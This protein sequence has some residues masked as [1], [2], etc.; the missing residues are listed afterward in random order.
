MRFGFTPST[1]VMW[2]GSERIQLE[3]GPRAIV[4]DDM[5][6]ATV[7]ELV[8]GRYEAPVS[9][10]DLLTA[11]HGAGFV[12]GRRATG[13]GPGGTVPASVGEALLAPDLAAMGGRYG[14]RAADV[15]AGRRRRRVSVRGSGR[16]PALIGSLLAAA[17]IGAVHVAGTGDVRLGDA[18]PGGLCAD[19][20]GARFVVAAGAAIHR[21]APAA[22]TSTLGPRSADLLVLTTGIPLP[23]EIGATL[24][25][26]GQAHVV[27]G[28]WGASAVIGPLVLPGRS[29]CLRCAD[30]QRRDRDPAWPALA[31]QL[32]AVRPVG[33]PS[34]VCV[35]SLAAAI[36]AL[37]CLQYLD[38]EAPTILDGT[39]EMTLPDWRLRRRTWP[40]HPDCNCA[41]PLGG[42]TVGD[43]TV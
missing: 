8:H 9:N 18:V 28:V 16:M 30:L 29:S 39:L 43:W 32:D 34:D 15:M 42:E 27:V 3:L 23:R 17:G 4:I 24:A 38:G 11:L 37:Q 14:E 10:R 36:T 41:M 1:R 33:E 40:V 2:R 35:V 13:S 26:T 7:A 21:A 31:A 25:S 12:T 22:D 5:D 6:P 20:E 19:D